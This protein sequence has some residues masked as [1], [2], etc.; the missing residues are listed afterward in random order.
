MLKAP[1]YIQAALDRFFP[2]VRLEWH[3]RLQWWVLTDFAAYPDG[4]PAKNIALGVTNMMRG[5][6]PWEKTNRGAIL[7]W[8]RIEDG[9]R[10]P[11]SLFAILETLRKHRRAPTKEAVNKSIDA[12]E[13]REEAAEAAKKRAEH[14]A[15][16]DRALEAWDAVKLSMFGAGIRR[17]PWTHGK[18][19]DAEYAKRT[20]EASNGNEAEADAEVARRLKS[21][22][23]ISQVRRS[24]RK[25]VG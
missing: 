11:L 23:G 16:R 17:T 10:E 15:S 9:W 8:G 24:P 19:V 2:G 12:L 25:V 13:A 14:A 4:M 21:G 20:R 18:A 6:A 3:P 5:I 22:Q 7:F 1:R